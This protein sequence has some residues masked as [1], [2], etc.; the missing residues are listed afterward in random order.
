MYNTAV[1]PQLILTRGALHAR[2]AWRFRSSAVALATTAFLIASV[3]VTPGAATAAVPRPPD[4]GSGGTLYLLQGSAGTLERSH[5]TLR[6]LLRG[7]NSKVTT[8][9]DRPARLG[10]TERLSTFV[11]N[12]SRSFGRVPPNAALL[13]DHAPASRDVALLE[14]RNP[15]YDGR[16]QTLSF[17]VKRLKETRN[18]HLRT[19]GRLADPTV[20]PRFGR[21]T[22]F[23]DNGPSVFGYQ[24]Q[25]NLLG[26]QSSQSTSQF[27][28]T[29]KNSQFQ[30]AGSLTQNLVFGQVSLPSIST[31]ISAQRTAF[32]FPNGQQLLGTF[33]IDLPSSGRSVQATVVLPPYYQLQ[34]YTEA[35]NVT[36]STS[37]SIT[38]PAPPPPRA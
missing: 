15:R 13:I 4:T 30:D 35:G 27:S 1:R 22:L 17:A 29:L 28:L 8:F 21:F 20:A 32:A 26:P 38:I 14:L 7:P 3:G 25:F 9:A 18:V 6:L 11:R 5:G 23:V 31:N 19:F 2:A 12:W 33:D 36:V 16:R 24:V 10:G 34:L 37:G